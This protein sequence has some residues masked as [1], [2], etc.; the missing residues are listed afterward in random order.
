[1][2]LHTLVHKAVLIRTQSGATYFL[3]PR[4][5]IN[6]G[7]LKVHEDNGIIADRYIQTGNPMNIVR[8]DDGHM[9]ITSPVVSLEE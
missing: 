8:L 9:I 6:G 3:R 5:R 7:S 4:R 1:M 2:T